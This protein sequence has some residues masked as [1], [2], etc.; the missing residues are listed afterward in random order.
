[1]YLPTT[2]PLLAGKCSPRLSDFCVRNYKKKKKAF[3]ILFFLFQVINTGISMAPN[4]SVKIMVPNSF[5]P[6]DDKLFNV[7]DVQVTVCSPCLT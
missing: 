7:L 3:K 6:Q 4:V 2:H 5:L 1:M